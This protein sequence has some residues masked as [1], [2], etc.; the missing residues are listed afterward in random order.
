[1]TRLAILSVALLSSAASAQP[2]MSGGVRIAPGQE[3][4]AGMT[5]VRPGNCQA[6][7][8]PPPSILDYRPRSTLVTTEHLVPKAKFP[9]IDY[10][11]HPTTQLASA[12]GL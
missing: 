2:G 4:P 1:M 3:C 11:G 10:H 9:A 6:P 12:E 8:L 7:T 5:E